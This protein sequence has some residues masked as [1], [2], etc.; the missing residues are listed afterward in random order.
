MLNTI[1][2][3]VKDYF[4]SS[5]GSASMYITKALNALQN[6]E[7]ETNTVEME[8]TQQKGIGAK[9][10]LLAAG[11]TLKTYSLPIKLHFSYCNPQKIIDE[12]EEKVKNKEAF[13]YFQGDKYKGC[14]VINKVS[15]QTISRTQSEIICAEVTVDL[16]E[17]PLPE[18]EEFQQQTKSAKKPESRLQTLRK[19]LQVPVKLKNT[20]DKIPDSIKAKG[21]GYLDDKSEGLAS[22]ALKSDSLLDVALRN[23]RSYLNKETNGISE[24]ILNNNS[25][26]RSAGVAEVTQ[27][28]DITPELNKGQL[29]ELIN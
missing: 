11:E 21:L 15:T 29:D 24:E 6:A 19:K 28:T 10:S 12:L 13:L 7:S 8:Y 25:V 23:G 27:V 17:S 1:K 16:L 3:V 26:S 2:S 20:L 18:G 4:E 22:E 9:P 14:Y 5:C